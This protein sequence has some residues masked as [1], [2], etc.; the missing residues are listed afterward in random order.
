M[1]LNDTDRATLVK[2][3]WERSRNILAEVDV[4]IANSCWYAAANRIYY[5]VFYAV[6]AL[7]I[8]DGY[9]IKS[10]RGAKNVLN[11]EYV[12]TGRIDVESAHFFA[13]LESLRDAADYNVFFQATE[14]EI[15]EYRP[16]VDIFI[17]D[18]KN[19]IGEI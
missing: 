8:K 7:F 3:Y 1:G 6:C 9:P 2:M 5:A 19:L 15:M 4:A 18:I 17:S 11:K 12:L 13:E 10:H 16:I 14:E